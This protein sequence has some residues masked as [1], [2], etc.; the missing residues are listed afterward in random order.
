MRVLICG[1]RHWYDYALVKQ[2][3]EE[4]IAN[5]DSIECIIEGGAHGADFCGKMAAVELSIPVEEFPADW[6]REGKRAGPIRNQKMLTEG[7]PD[8]VLA[9]H[10]NFDNSKGTR[11]MIRL[12]EKAGVPYS[13]IKHDIPWEPNVTVHENPTS[14][15]VA[16]PVRPYRKPSVAPQPVEVEPRDMPWTKGPYISKKRWTNMDTPPTIYAREGD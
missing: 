6:E 15:L 1:D 11:S 7:R 16:L 3:I 8:W 5:V 9:F 13:I 14:P 10:D 4:F 2:E 12:A